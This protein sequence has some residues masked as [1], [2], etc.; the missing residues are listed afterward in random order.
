MDNLES[1]KIETEPHRYIYRDNK[2]GG[3]VIFECIA[4]NI[5]DADKMYE[6]KTGKILSGKTILVVLSKK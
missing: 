4:S 5:L 1:G 3:K 2:S 6:E